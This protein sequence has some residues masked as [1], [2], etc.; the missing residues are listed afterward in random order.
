MPAGLAFVPIKLIE[1]YIPIF[2]TSYKYKHIKIIII[3]YRHCSHLTTMEIFLLMFFFL[4]S[5]LKLNE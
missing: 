3:L 4:L 5:S 2:H 1:I